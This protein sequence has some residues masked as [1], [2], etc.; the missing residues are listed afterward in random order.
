MIIIIL[1]Y[2]ANKQQKERIFMSTKEKPEVGSITWFDLT[3]PDADKVK[4]FY[5]KVIG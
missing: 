3:V 5:S 1:S 4:D 2:L